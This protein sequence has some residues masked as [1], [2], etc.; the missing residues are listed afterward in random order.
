[1][2]ARKCSGRRAYARKTL[3]TKPTFARES[4][5]TA[6][7][8]SGISSSAGTPK[9]EGAASC[10]A[11]SLNGGWLL[12]RGDVPA[13]DIG[14]DVRCRLVHVDR[15]GA[16]LGLGEGDAFD[17]RLRR[18]VLHRGQGVLGFGSSFAHVPSWM[19]AGCGP[20][21]LPP[22]TWTT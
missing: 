11:P 3:G 19:W 8:S 22:V 2:K 9:R 16:L 14:G 18:S 15:E 6:R 5:Q 7:T 4:S 17:R 20:A 12:G 21:L 1:M 10:A 13:A